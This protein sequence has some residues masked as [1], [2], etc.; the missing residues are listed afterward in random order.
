MK[1]TL[2]FTLGMALVLCACSFSASAAELG[3]GMPYCRTQDA[4]ARLLIVHAEKGWE[5][6]REE[7]GVLSSQ[8]T[9]DG[10][11]LCDRIPQEEHGTIMSIEPG[12]VEVPDRD[13][14][15]HRM[16]IFSF[17]RDGSNEVLYGVMTADPDPLPPAPPRSHGI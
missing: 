1:N 9:S 15:N 17:T 11:A 7:H 16:T 10:K 2:L 6:V 3:Q 4:I 5:A 14:E 13:G 8:R 12:F